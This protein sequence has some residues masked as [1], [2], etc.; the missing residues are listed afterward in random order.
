M[1][2]AFLP[3]F[4]II[5]GVMLPISLKFGPEKGRIILIVIFGLL[6]TIAIM[7]K[8]IL[9]TAVKDLHIDFEAIIKKLDAIPQQVLA[10][11]LA[12]LGTLVFLISMAI[13]IGIMKKKEY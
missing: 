9:E 4:L 11:S 12:G 2:V 3:A 13:S 8:K 7:G 1:D 5:V 10:L 6:F